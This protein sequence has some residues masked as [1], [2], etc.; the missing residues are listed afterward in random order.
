MK[1]PLLTTGLNGLVGSR[2]A[3]D[4]AD[5]YEFDNLDL[6]DLT[7][8]TDITQYEQV[9]GRFDN[10]PAT[11]VIHLAAYTDVTGAWQQ[12]DDTRGVAYQVNVV[13]TENIIKAAEATKKHVVYVSTAYVFDGEKKALYTEEDTP[14]PIE[15]YGKTKYLAEEIVK[16]STTPW[17]ILRIDMPF[18]SDPFEKKDTVHR[19][20]TGIQDGTLYPQFTNHFFGPTYLNDFSKVL[21]LVVRTQLAGLYH[22]SSGEQWTDYEFAKLINRTLKLGGEIQKGDLEAYLV[23]SARPYQ[24]NTA[25]STAKLNK[26][27]DFTPKTIDEAIA[28]IQI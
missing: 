13:G 9:L 11:H 17:T 19:I 21:D 14:N 26:V 20:I 8:P 16:Q 10:S 28:A 1:T 3:L 27:L 4:F 2:F 23:K 15:W 22:A 7:Q 25:M 24:R 5:S 12:T 18:R 6:R